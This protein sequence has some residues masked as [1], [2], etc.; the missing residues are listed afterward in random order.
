[1]DEGQAF[2]AEANGPS[3]AKCVVECVV[4]AAEAVGVDLALILRD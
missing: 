2:A 1:M 3:Y 4:V